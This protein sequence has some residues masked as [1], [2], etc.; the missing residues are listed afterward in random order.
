MGEGG[1]P[2]Q[3][4]EEAVR[5][6]QARDERR[7]D[8]KGLRSAIDA[9]EGEFAGEVSATQQSGD[10]LAFGMASAVGWLSRS[11]GMSENSVSDRLCV[12]R[13]LESL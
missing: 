9:L 4:L 2:L 12:G 7:V 1:T 8:A 11:C 3:R 13:H 10:H 6:F 5:E